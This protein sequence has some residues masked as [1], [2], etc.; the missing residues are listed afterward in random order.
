MS[1]F[2]A[3][4]FDEIIARRRRLRETMGDR[5]QSISEFLVLGGLMIG[6]LGLFLR[7]WMPAAAPWGFAIPVLFLVGYALIEARRQRAAAALGEADADAAAALARTYDWRFVLW[8]LFCAVAGAAAFAIAWSAE[9][10][11]P[12]EPEGWTPPDG[13]VSVEISP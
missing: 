5:G 4:L 3:S 6:S 13:A 10:A 1:G 2:L 11:Q 12:P 9:P 7:P 8:S